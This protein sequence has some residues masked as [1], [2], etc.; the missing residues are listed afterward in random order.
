MALLL[1]RFPD[2]SET[3]RALVSANEDFREI[4]EH[5]ALARIALKRFKRR[6]AEHQKPEVADYKIVV[7]ELEQEILDYIAFAPSPNKQ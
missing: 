1:P 5:Y 2:K 7:A 3:I 4:C 6:S